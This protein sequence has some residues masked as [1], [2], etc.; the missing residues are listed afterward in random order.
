MILGYQKPT[1]WHNFSRNIFQATVVKSSTVDPADT[2][3][4]EPKKEENMCWSHVDSSM[5]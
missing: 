5:L 2:A 3:Q 4:W 1:S